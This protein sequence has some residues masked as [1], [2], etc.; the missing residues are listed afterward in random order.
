MINFSLIIPC[1]NPEIEDLLRIIK[2][3]YGR[4]DLEIIF[5]DGGSVSRIYRNYL[6]PHPRC[7][8]VDMP[9]YLEH[10]PGNTRQTGLEMAMG[11][12][13]F[14]CDQDDHFADTINESLD[15]VL[16][17]I[18]KLN[19]PPLITTIMQTVDPETGEIDKEYPHNQAWLHGKFYNHNFIL[20]HGIRFKKDLITHEDVY[21]NSA[22]TAGLIDT[23]QAPV[24]M[25]VATYCWV[26]NP[27]SLT[28]RFRDDRGYFYENFQDYVIAA[29]GP[30]WNKAFDLSY[31]KEK[32]ELYF[33]QV[34]MTLLHCYF[35]YEAA[36]FY[37]GP[38]KYK[39]IYQIIRR[40]VR[41][42][43]DQYPETDSLTDITNELV[44]YIYQDPLLYHMVREDCEDIANKFIEKTSYKDW[45]NYIV[46]DCVNI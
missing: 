25:D 23:K 40:F 8:F 38:E 33:H 35:Y 43:V 17:T 22:V 24:A 1:Y 27:E 14:F 36:S 20:E 12:Y 34:M 2:P 13:I 30:Y 28:R 15:A 37:E 46:K 29:S 31:D 45:I 42:I 10:C 18:E 5:A 32:R 4:R 3:F 44:N 39:D 41:L 6:C 26:N 16:L 19:N 21:F 9:E 11:D 7:S